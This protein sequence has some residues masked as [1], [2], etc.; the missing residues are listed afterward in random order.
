[1]KE[2]AAQAEKVMTDRDLRTIASGGTRA[3]WT[4]HY[5]PKYKRCF[6]SAYYFSNEPIKGGPQTYT[7][8]IDAFERSNLASTASGVEAETACRGQEKP[9]D[10]EAT[11]HKL[12]GIACKIEDE[13]TDCAKAKQFIEGHMKN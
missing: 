10:C 2:C 9:A 12:W 11:A 5:S 6:V 7:I 13:P 8:L 4:N 3:D 1:M